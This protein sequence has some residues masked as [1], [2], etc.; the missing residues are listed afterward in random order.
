MY[1]FKTIVRS[2]KKHLLLIIMTTFT[3]VIASVSIC[4]SANIKEYLDHTY[5]SYKTIALFE[6]VGGAYPDDSVYSPF[7]E[8]AAQE[9]KKL[10]IDHR[11]GVINW[12]IP[13]NHLGYVP[14]LL[15]RDETAIYKDRAVLVVKASA[16]NATGQ[17]MATVEKAFFSIIPIEGLIIAINS[18]SIR[19]EPGHYYLIHG[20]YTA[21]NSSLTNIIICSYHNQIAEEEGVQCNIENMCQDVTNPNGNYSIPKDSVLLNVARSYEVLNNSVQITSTSDVSSLLPFIQE[22]LYIVK[23][24]F[25]SPDEYQHEEKACI[26]SQRF[27]EL[28]NV[29]LNDVVSFSTVSNSKVNKNE[30]YWAGKGFDEIEE[31]QVVGITSGNNKYDYEVF[32]PKAKSNFKEGNYTYI[33]GNA[34]L[35]NNR[36]VS[37]Y[38]DIVPQLPDNVRVT[39]FDQGWSVLSGPLLRIKR[40]ATIILLIGFFCIIAFSALFGYLYAYN[41][42]KTIFVMDRIGLDRGKIIRYYVFGTGLVCIFAA[43]FGTIVSHFIIP[44][45]ESIF[46]QELASNAIESIKEYSNMSLSVVRP[47]GKIDWKIRRSSYVGG[48][49]VIV[50]SLIS[51]IV[52]IFQAIK[53]PTHQSKK[54]FI[55]FHVGRSASLHG[56]SIKYAWLSFTRGGMRTIV[57]LAFISAIILLMQHFSTTRVSYYYQLKEIQKE[58]KIQGAFTDASGR[59]NHGLLIEGYMVNELYNTGC[60]DSFCVTSEETIAYMGRIVKN[61]EKSVFQSSPF[62]TTPSGI[63]AY[64]NSTIMSKD[65]IVYTNDISKVPEFMRGKHPTIDYLDTFSDSSFSEKLVGD[66]PWLIVPTRFLESHALQVGDTIRLMHMKNQQTQDYLIAGKYNGYGSNN[67]L[68]CQLSAF[69]SLDLLLGH[70]EIVR[71]DLFPYIFDSFSF[72]IVQGNKLS[73][74]K[75]FL[76]KKG[77]SQ[78]GT[79]RERRCFIVL[80]DALYLNTTTQ[81]EKQISMLSFLLIIVE[82]ASFLIGFVF[83]LMH[84]YEIKIMERL[85]TGRIRTWMNVMI[86]LILICVFGQIIALVIWLITNQSSISATSIICASSMFLIGAALC[87]LVLCS[88]RNHHNKERED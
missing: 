16:P 4:L 77:Y 22:E 58:A 37:F 52:F 24:R 49:I 17:Y 75:E 73:D 46:D 40:I 80:N 28:I 54:R 35:D 21:G 48:C 53:M 79:I 50:F 67:T 81:L 41:N 42:R 86:E 64:M 31:Y 60:L 26:I 76:H 45:F 38:D 43:A 71:T 1:F 63:E 66:Y 33:L 72:T 68:Y 83:V 5:S 87:N 15:R 19:L 32:F 8:D 59:Q 34:L 36:A 65:K 27:A 12:D 84:H 62:P 70:D 56:G 7:A 18:M 44:L 13:I 88:N 11:D 39:I 3:I 30:C 61:G 9:I 82:I 78:I 29:D 25:F 14:G 57:S 55:A 10:E 74:V 47:L 85:G 20:Q 51:C 6:Y 2:W 69:V 23:G